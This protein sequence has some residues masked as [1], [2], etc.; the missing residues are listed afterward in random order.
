MG[1]LQAVDWLL[2]QGALEVLPALGSSVSCASLQ[3]A[4]PSMMALRGTPGFALTLN[5]QCLFLAEVAV[6]VLAFLCQEA[7]HTNTLPIHFFVQDWEAFW[8]PTAKIGKDRSTLLAFCSH[9]EAMP[10]RAVWEWFWA[11]SLHIL[12]MCCYILTSPL[13][14]SWAEELFDTLV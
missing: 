10:A 14:V 4:G 13:M 2:C 8:C 12:T 5:W 9:R 11:G 3:L 6:G 7:L 1:I